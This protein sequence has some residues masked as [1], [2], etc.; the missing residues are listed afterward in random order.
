M[1]A[2][3]FTNKLEFMKMPMEKHCHNAYQGLTFTRANPPNVG[4]FQQW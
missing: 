1:Q 2:I 4:G 3:N